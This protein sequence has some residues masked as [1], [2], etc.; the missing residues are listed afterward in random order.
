MK[1]VAIFLAAALSATA[2]LGTGD[3]HADPAAMPSSDELTQQLSVIFDN[4]ANS[5]QRA[6]YLEGGNAALPVADSI[7]GPIAEHR[8]MVSLHVENPTLEGDHVTSQLVMSVMGIGSQSRPMNWL[9]RGG[10]WK[11]SNG[12]LCRLFSETNRGTRCPL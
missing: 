3:A 4:T 6:S 10:M 9:E 5:A 8:S 7:G 2:V 11:L 12:S 1:H